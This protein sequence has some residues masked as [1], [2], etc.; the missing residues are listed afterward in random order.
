MAQAQL[1]VRYYAA[2]GAATG[3][4]EERVDR[5]ATVGELKN[6]LRRSHPSLTSVLVA[7]SLL[8]DGVAATSD[9]TQLSDVTEVD[10]LPPFA[11]G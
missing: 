11:G 10:V 7:S 1:T 9:D 2:A 6:S 8:L 4:P 3:V 5:P